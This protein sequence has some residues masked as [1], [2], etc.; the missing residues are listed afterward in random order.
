MLSNVAIVVAGSVMRCCFTFLGNAP[1]WAMGR[2]A[3]WLGTS[4]YSIYLC[5]Q[6]SKEATQ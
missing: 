4:G 1:Q 5:W 2:K 6:S 3:L